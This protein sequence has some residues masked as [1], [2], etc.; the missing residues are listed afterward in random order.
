MFVVANDRIRIKSYFR[1]LPQT[2]S[3]GSWTD[4]RKVMGRSA[5]AVID[6][7][8]CLVAGFPVVAI[9]TGMVTDKVTSMGP[10]IMIGLEHAS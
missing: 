3:V 1:D 5:L 6:G 10:A 4:K 8:I 7:G 2:I 9:S